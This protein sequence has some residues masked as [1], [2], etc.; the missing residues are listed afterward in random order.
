[1]EKNTGGGN[2]HGLSEFTTRKIVKDKCFPSTFNLFIHKEQKGKENIMSG[3]LS[4]TCLVQS[5]NKIRR[6]LGSREI[7]KYDC[8][9]RRGAKGT[10]VPLKKHAA[11]K[12]LICIKDVL[13]LTFTE[14]ITKTVLHRKE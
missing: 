10:R 1:M 4:Y 7:L 14:Q 11:V 12:E 8:L 9:K 2:S 3:V 6:T 13:V 5:R